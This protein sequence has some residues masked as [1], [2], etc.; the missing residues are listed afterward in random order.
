M[1]KE[2][3]IPQAASRL[4]I[5]RWT[6]WK[7]VTSGK[8]KA[9]RTPGGHYRISEADLNEFKRQHG[10]SIKNRSTTKRILIVDDDP[11]VREFLPKLISDEGHEIDFAKDGFEAG[12]KIA[13]FAPDMIILDLVMPHMDGFEVCRMLKYDS[14][15]AHI[16]ILAI[17]GMEGDEVQDKILEAGADSFM[18]KPIAVD[19]FR[20]YVKSLLE[21]SER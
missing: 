19:V 3:S 5:S 1:D 10:P 9:S 8:L 2:L 15:T 16:K 11:V 17:T 4:S 12:L 14:A 18:K 13:K 6:L 21:E 20:Y 7:Y